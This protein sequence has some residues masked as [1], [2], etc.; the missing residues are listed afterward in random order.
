MSEWISSPAKLAVLASVACV[1]GYTGCNSPPDSS[2]PVP[3]GEAD[4][5]APGFDPTSC[6]AG[7][8]QCPP[9][10]TK[11]GGD[12]DCPNDLDI[13]G[14]WFVKVSAPGKLKSDIDDD[15]TIDAWIRHFVSPSGDVTFNICKLTVAGST[16][17]TTYPQ[18]LVDTLQ[19]SGKQSTR[20]PIGGPVV[21]PSFTIY[22]GQTSDGASV[23]TRPPPFPGG[24]GD[25]HPGVTIPSTV[26][27]LF[28]FDVD[29]YAGLVITINMSGVTLSNA[30]TMAGSTSF[31]THVV[32]FESS[33][34][35]LVSPNSTIDVTTNN[36]KV[37]FA[38]TKL[39]SDGSHDCA[40]IAGQ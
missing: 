24:D 10:C 37:P 13:S 31:K 11:T 32:A 38:A 25:G 27:L 14:T 7:D 23:D 12:T 18:A 28:S 35:T 2:T 19:A 15:V 6:V 4:G 20:A 3:D 29:V 33:S 36:P 9:G 30:S 16:I 17:R 5:G 21:L 26:K 22:S 1:V 8:G 34:H 40:F 39:D